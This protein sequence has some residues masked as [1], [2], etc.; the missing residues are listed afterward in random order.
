DIILVTDVVSSGKTVLSIVKLI[1]SYYQK[2]F[3]KELV[4]RYHSISVISDSENTRDEF[5]KKMHTIKTACGSLRMPTIHVADL[6]STD[7][8]PGQIDFTSQP[9]K[10]D[11]I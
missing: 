3:S 4:V 5:D 1:E 8:L 2:T 10:P 11:F 9:T 6:P 7:I